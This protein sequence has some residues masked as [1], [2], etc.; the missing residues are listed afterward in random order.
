MDSQI[1]AVVLSFVFVFAIIFAATL[2]KKYLKI[3]EF[4]TRKIIHI[5]VGNWVICAFYLFTDWYIAI[6]PPI[7]FI[8][9]NY[10][11]YRYTIFKAMELEEKN[12]GTVYYSIS[13]TILTFF[14]FYWTP[15]LILPYLGIM[16]MVWGDG[17]A[18]LIGRAYPIKKISENKSLGGSIAF[19]VM[20]SI[21]CF[22]YLLINSGGWDI[23]LMIKL[24]LLFS[25]IGTYVELRTRR[26]I[27]NLTVPLLVGLVGVLMERAL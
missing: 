14:T 10:L 4:T 18:A 11:S 20:S 21:A 1:V 6:V 9:V 13:L 22:V 25:I 26:S 15:K 2:L 16:A 17:F 23:S 24:A 27:D 19:L 7:T 12:P 8:I 3:S 5:G